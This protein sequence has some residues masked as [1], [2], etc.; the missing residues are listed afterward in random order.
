MRDQLLE[1]A[2]QIDQCTVVL[3]A[4]TGAFDWARKFEALGHHEDHQPAICEAVRVSA[5]E[6]LQRRRGDLHRLRD[7]L[8]FPWFRRRPSS[9]RIFKRSIALGSE[10]SITV[11]LSSGQ[12]RGL[13]LDRGLA[14]AK[15]ITWA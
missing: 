2:A 7:N 11:Q 3:E 1:G 10:W 14:M 5:E 15:S 12:I 6:Q 13:L 9:N 8:T 4:C